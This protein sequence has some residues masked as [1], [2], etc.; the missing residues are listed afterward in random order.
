MIDAPPTGKVI[1]RLGHRLQPRQGTGE[2]GDRTRGPRY[3][4]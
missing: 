3:F 2:A 1:W 4:R